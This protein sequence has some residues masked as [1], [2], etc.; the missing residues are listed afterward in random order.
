M[1]EQ[2]DS[3]GA[4]ANQESLPGVAGRL[5]TVGQQRLYMR[6]IRVE[7]CGAA[8]Q[9]LSFPWIAAENNR[10]PTSIFAMARSLIE[11]RK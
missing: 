2:F 6:I 7:A 1:T 9:A 5:E 10:K 4:M 8:Q 3:S 11:A